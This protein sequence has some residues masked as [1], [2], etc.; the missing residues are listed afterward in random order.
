MFNEATLET[1]GMQQQK[2]L[3]GSGQSRVVLTVVWTELRWSWAVTA[4]GG[5]RRKC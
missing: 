5:G 3:G 1:A 2:A 4:G